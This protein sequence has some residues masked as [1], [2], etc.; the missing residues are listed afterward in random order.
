MRRWWSAAARGPRITKE[1]PSAMVNGRIAH[2]GE[3]AEALLHVLQWIWAI[4]YSESGWCHEAQ[5]SGEDHR[6]DQVGLTAK[7][8]HI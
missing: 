3:I 5:R 1:T 2:G 8:L 6:E 4:V 7:G